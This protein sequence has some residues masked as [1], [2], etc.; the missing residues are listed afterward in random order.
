MKSLLSLAGGGSLINLWKRIPAVIKLPM[1]FGAGVLAAAELNIDANHSWFSNRIFGGQAAQGEAQMVDPADTRKAVAEGKH[2]S[3][4]ERMIE[5]QVSAGDA[6]ARTKTVYADAALESEA[7][8][9]RKKARGERMTSTEELRLKELQLKEQELRSA[10]A[11]ADTKVAQATA[12]KSS[13][14]ATNY[15]NRDIIGDG[16]GGEDLANR[17]MAETAARLWGKP[18]Q[19]RQGA[20]GALVD[21]AETALVPPAF[22]GPNWRPPQPRRQDTRQNSAR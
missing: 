8:L 10:T 18:A 1:V 22:R 19:Q 14:D 5:V 3:G 12:A 11:E 21:R 17:M 4:A 16:K 20:G 9:L 6:D 2:V 15:I 13:A 7:E